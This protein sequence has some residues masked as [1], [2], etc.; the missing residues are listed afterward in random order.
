ME[1]CWILNLEQTHDRNCVISLDALLAASLIPCFVI[2]HL[3]SYPA[4]TCCASSAL[5]GG[6]LVYEF[7]IRLTIPTDVFWRHFRLPILEFFKLEYQPD[8]AAISSSGE[9]LKYGSLEAIVKPLP[10]SFRPS[11]RTTKSLGI[12]VWDVGCGGVE[13]TCPTTCFQG[14]KSLTMD[15]SMLLDPS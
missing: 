3:T 15:P 4:L 8:T 1:Y 2:T 5:R 6:G 10:S 11:R 14:A 9:T 7:A 13:R 12:R